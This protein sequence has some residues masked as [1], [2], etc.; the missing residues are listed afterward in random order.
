MVGGFIF[1][2]KM[3]HF[4]YLTPSDIG[5]RI[6]W[7]KVFWTKI[8]VL[9]FQSINE[10]YN[11]GKLSCTQR[12]GV[13]TLLHKGKNLPRNSLGNWRLFILW[14]LVRKMDFLFLIHIMIMSDRLVEIFFI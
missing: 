14:K 8:G 4:L 3:A 1:Q 2:Q 13:V 12:R 5:I 6:V 10:G 9:V 11:I 7:Y